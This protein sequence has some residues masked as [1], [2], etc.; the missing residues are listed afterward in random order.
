MP[1]RCGAYVFDSS[2]AARE[3]WLIGVL[4]TGALFLLLDLHESGAF[5]MQ[6]RGFVVLAKIALL[7]A[8]PLFPG[9]E[10]W[11]LGALIAVSVLSSHAPGAVRYR[12][13]WG[14]GTI[15][16]SESSG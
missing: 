1:T 7:A 9:Y 16:G 4:A 10:A 2:A 13:L 12:M 8:L 5:L 15:Q 3:P 11:I 6:V 14:G